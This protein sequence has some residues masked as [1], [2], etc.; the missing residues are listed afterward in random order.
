MP[1]LRISKQFNLKKSDSVIVVYGHVNDS[2]V[3]SDLTLYNIDGIEKIICRL[4]HTAG[5]DQI[6][7]YSPERLLYT[8][9]EQ[10]YHYCF[11]QQQPVEQTSIEKAARYDNNSL[12]DRRPLGA[13]KFFKRASAN[14][15][16]ASTAASPIDEKI[17][18]NTREG[19]ISVLRGRADAAILDIIREAMYQKKRKSAIILSQFDHIN[20]N[21]EIQRTLIPNITRFLQHTSNNKCFIITN[22]LD[23]RDLEGVISSIPALGKIV[24]MD[25]ADKGLDSLIYIGYPHKDEIRNLINRERI[26]KEKAIDWVHL[27][28][29]VRAVDQDQNELKRWAADFDSINH[30]DIPSLNKILHFPMSTNDQSAFKKLDALVGLSEVKKAIRN[31]VFQ[32]QEMIEENPSKKPLMHIVLKGNPGTGK[33]TIA[34]IIAEILREERLLERGHLVEVDR[35][36]LVAGFVGQTAIKTDS[37]C[38]EALGGVLFVDEAYGLNTSDSDAFG[39]EAVNTLIKRMTDWQSE[40]CVVLAGYPK[41]MNELLKTNEGFRRRISFTIEIADYKPQELMELFVQLIKKAGKT[42]TAPFEEAMTSI[43]TSLYEKR[44]EKIDE[45][46]DN[47]GRVE[48]AY[49]EISSLRRGRCFDQKLD[50]KNEP[51]RLEDLPKA[52][53]GML[54]TVN[55]DQTIEDALKELNEFEGLKAVKSYVQ[56]LVDAY[57]HW[58]KLL[59]TNPQAQPNKKNYHMVFT[60]NP[61]TGK[62]TVARILGK[63]FKA[64]G[65]LEE[66]RVIETSR[67]DFVA[68][69]QGQTGEKTTKL[70]DSAINNILFIDEAYSL[71]HGYGDSYG[72]EAIVIL[73]KMMEDNR[74][75]LVVVATGYPKEMKEFLETNPGLASRFAN[76]IRFDDYD[77]KE[78]CRILKREIIVRGFILQENLDDEVENSLTQYKESKGGNFGN[79]RDVLNYLDNIVMPRYRK[80]VEDMQPE[81]KLFR[82]II[83]EDF[84]ILSSSLQT[85]TD[86][87]SATDKV[88]IDFKKDKNTIEKQ[89]TVNNINYG[90]GYIVAGNN[91]INH[92]YGKAGNELPRNLTNFPKK[93]EAEIFGRV[94]KVLEIHQK[95]F[96]YHGSVSVLVY[97]LPGIGKTTAIIKFMTLYADAFEHIIWLKM[98]GSIAKTFI[99]NDL[100]LRNLGINFTE[101]QDE[102]ARFNL[103]F[104]KLTSLKRNCLLIMEGLTKANELEFNELNFENFKIIGSSRERLNI[105]EQHTIF[106]EPLPPNEASLLFMSIYGKPLN[107]D[108]DEL[109]SPVSYHPLAVE[110]LA[111]ILKS[112]PNL[113]EEQLLQ[114]VQQGLNVRKGET[115]LEY[116]TDNDVNIRVNDIFNN[117]FNI[118]GLRKDELTILLYF[119]VLPAYFMPIDILYR[120]LKLTDEDKQNWFNDIIAALQ[121]KG[122]IVEGNNHSY[123][124]PQIIQQVCRN[125]AKPGIDNCQVLFETLGEQLGGEIDTAITG[126]GLFALAID[127][128]QILENFAAHFN[129]DDLIKYRIYINLSILYRINGQFNK[130]I[131]TGLIEKEA[132]EP[133]KFE[134]PVWYN[135][136]TRNIA[137][138]CLSKSWYAESEKYYKE[139]VDFLEK[140]NLDGNE[141]KQDIERELILNYTQLGILQLSIEK[142][143]IPMAIEYYNKGLEISERS[144]HK[145]PLAT[146]ALKEALALAQI[147]ENKFEPA[148]VNLLEVK[149]IIIK[150]EKFDRQSLPV[151]LLHLILALAYGGEG[152]FAEARRHLNIA[153]DNFEKQLPKNSPEFYRA[154]FIAAMVEMLDAFNLMETTE[155]INK[156][157]FNRAAELYLKAIEIMK[158]SPEKNNQNMA[159]LLSNYGLMLKF[160]GHEEKGYHEQMKAVEI[161]KKLGYTNDFIAGIFIR[162]IIHFELQIPDGEIEDYLKLCLHMMPENAEKLLYTSYIR[163][164]LGFYKHKHQKL[165]EGINDL[166]VALYEIRR[167]YGKDKQNPDNDSQLEVIYMQKIASMHSEL[168][169]HSSAI[170]VQEEVVRIF[171]KHLKSD[172]EDL[173]ETLVNMAKIYWAAAKDTN[174]K[175]M[176]SKTIQY[177]TEAFNLNKEMVEKCTELDD[178][179]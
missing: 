83:L 18:W 47:A 31:Y 52:Y 75:R 118:A 82:E 103:I 105:A 96:T 142:H 179:G 122:F 113:H 167:Y 35:E 128:L 55:D 40:F 1:V 154:Y 13:K 156:D 34:R 67:A 161:Y 175:E 27:E 62:T 133:N 152:N 144:S 5:Y 121:Q 64:L 86:E 90:Q 60:G 137:F 114:Q 162:T 110:I 101:N 69:Y 107:V 125:K 104:A 7:F 44:E 70:I 119:S 127:Y 151:G 46:F 146:A 38:K 149:D 30:I 100:L 108:I 43:F 76:T 28:R 36:K 66:G 102:K 58:Q 87:G 123:Y 59:K 89:V 106:I 177:K 39:K 164:S 21:H 163:Y 24:K 88:S 68:S 10:S 45:K 94:D 171:K 158:L 157:M 92:Y 160:A 169:D 99:E 74:N 95:L 3:T 168:K 136:I 81:N 141:E 132:L 78:M 42:M 97:G 77:S 23:P 9:D 16:S 53:L 11:P 139:G 134:Y 4:L 14:Q 130:S 112:S 176:H 165:R 98:N 25:E 166:D 116:L 56:E 71:S 15:Q 111:K 131:D 85:F 19:F 17:P 172:D 174:D 126:V 140:I 63:I 109:L 6:I 93:A 50:T 138:T 145:D 22:A 120:I 72:E 150:D 51:Y 159:F 147:E 73:M 29:M 32:I 129:R 49:F 173:A 135:V 26:M 79:A 20:A 84:S 80:R 37:C 54:P 57:K 115:D 155:K 61:G 178:V 65:I 153:F 117:L 48:Q 2:F 124:C 33:T 12:S 148:I 170:G 8:Y 143:N 41:G 91:S